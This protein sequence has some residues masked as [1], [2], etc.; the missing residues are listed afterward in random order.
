MT[1]TDFIEKY[2]S[3][4][5]DQ[6]L[7]AV[8]TVNGPVLLLAVPGSGKTTVLVNR[9]GYM[10]YTQGIAPENIL[11][12]TYTV[13]A[14]KDMSERFK[15]IFGD[16]LADRLE[17][18][19]ING[20]CAKIIAY[21]GRM[22]GKTAFEL[23]SDE[24]ET[25]KLLSNIYVQ[26]TRDYPTESDIKT[27]RTL[28]TYCKNMSLTSDEIK[29]LGKEN[30]LELLKIYEG[31]N[32]YLKNNSLMDYDDQMVY[33]YK[34]LKGSKVVLQYFQNQYQYICVDEAQDT[35]KI[36]HMI[37]SILAGAGGNLFMVGDE[38]QSIYGFRAAYP[39]ALLNFEREHIGAKVLVM[40]KNYRSNGAIVQAADSFIQHNKDRHKKHICAIRESKS[41]INFVSIE[42]DK[43]YNY[44]K[45]VAKNPKG[46]TAVLYRD[47]ES[48]IP[49]V[50]ILDREGIPYNIKNMDMTFFSNRVVLDIV[51]ILRF[52]F[53]PMDEEIF[54]KIYYK[55]QAYISKSVAMDMC[56]QAEI[57][58]TG[59][60]D[61]AEFIELNPY[62]LGNCRSLRTHFK[63]MTKESPYKAI[64][65]IE[66]YMGYGEYL[67]N[68]NIDA[69]KIFILKMIAKKEKD[70]PGFLNRLTELRQLLL[71]Q[72]ASQGG[73]IIL[74][75]IHSS[76]GLE[77]D[78]VYLIDAINGV[79]PN[80]VVRNMEKATPQEKS[81][82]EEERRIFYVGIT[83]AKDN[84]T[85]FKYKN[86]PSTF[87]KELNPASK[88]EAKAN[89]TKKE[90]H[91]SPFAA[92][93]RY[94][95]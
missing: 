90:Y 6:Q 22:I 71:E 69:N 86:M 49:L 29:K 21:Y 26:V 25:A 24:K 40:D 66:N 56:M 9:L 94:K 77:Y 43:Q 85:V 16:E 61:A 14:T 1:E 50:D 93:G 53:V 18:R 51:N 72:E 48:V 23:C 58:H 27:L 32:T 12:L 79:F 64:K 73:R 11:T 95:K 82:Y 88:A 52:A 4:L 28:I 10:I 67:A 44:L 30:D 41:E 84:L 36:Q 62:V 65:R 59:I 15:R 37:I 31:Y 8:K 38:D 92:A 46:K 87:I 75:T 81:D 17:F 45:E 2:A 7:E 20:I 70:I 63:N 54:M 35:S 76:K 34:I 80:K 78:S 39:D 57:H 5:N 3:K 19:T 91:Y 33:A 47:N 42:R 89:T 68:N 60:L 13:A 74:S 55:L 83:R